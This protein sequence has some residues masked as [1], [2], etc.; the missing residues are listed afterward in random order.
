MSL[1]VTI[2]YG[3]TVNDS[4]VC[5]YFASA[6]PINIECERKDFAVVDTQDDGSGNTQINVTGTL[7]TLTVGGFVYVA[8]GTVTSGL[9]GKYTILSAT[10]STIVIDLAF[11]GAYTGGY[12]NLITDRPNYFIYSRLR[13]AY[14]T[15]PLPGGEVP[16]IYRKDF[17]NTLGVALIDISENISTYFTPEN[18]FGFDVTDEIDTNNCIQYSIEFKECWDDSL[19]AWSSAEYVNAVN[20]AMQIQNTGG[21]NMVN[22]IT[23]GVNDAAYFL[24]DQTTTRYWEGLPFDLQVLLYSAEFKAFMD[25]NPA[26]QLL[27]LEKRYTQVS[28]SP[29]VATTVLS[30]GGTLTIFDLYRRLM[31]A[32]SYASNIQFVDVAIAYEYSPGLY[33]NLTNFARIRIEPEIPCKPVYLTWLNKKGGWHYYCFSHR[34]QLGSKIASEGEFTKSFESLA[35]QNTTSS[36]LSKSS[37]NYMTCG[38]EQMDSSDIQLMISLIESPKVFMLMNSTTWDATAPVWREVKVDVGDYKTFDTKKVYNNFELKL[39]LAE[40]FTQRN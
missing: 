14:P 16:Y 28:A 23:S 13:A 22:Y 24:A 39:R 9:Y 12:V 30:S 20:A 33:Q 19:E 38:A 4:D 8:A 21:S 10:A 18:D 2:P 35:T 32:G 36:F 6:N 34:Q 27:R 40:T 15:F 17:P 11:S 5:E 37:E 25:A 7:P 1:T 3:V 31:I 26:L 29:S